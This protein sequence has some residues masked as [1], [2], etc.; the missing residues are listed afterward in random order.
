[1]GNPSPADIEE[2]KRAA[3]AAV[4]ATRREAGS[5]RRHRP[6]TGGAPCPGVA[7]EGIA[8]WSSTAVHTLQ[9]WIIAASPSQGTGTGETGL[10]E[11]RAEVAE[12]KATV[13]R[14]EAQP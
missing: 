10:R 1:M 8:Q 5:R 2:E 3:N 6:T 13:S 7:L 12:D 9:P 4:L 11:Q 14:Q